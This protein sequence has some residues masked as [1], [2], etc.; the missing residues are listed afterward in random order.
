MYEIP[1]LGN[2]RHSNSRA[3]ALTEASDAEDEER[4]FRADQGA[5]RAVIVH[6]GR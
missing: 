6:T 4:S 5:F 3:Q 2:L 1:E